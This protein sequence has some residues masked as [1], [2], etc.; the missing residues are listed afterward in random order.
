MLM[1]LSLF[2][3]PWVPRI[4]M[5]KLELVLLG[6]QWWNLAYK[7]FG[8]STTS[9]RLSSLIIKCLGQK[10]NQNYKDTIDK[11]K[12]ASMIK[13]YCSPWIHSRWTQIFILSACMH[14]ACMWYTRACMCTCT[15]QV[16]IIQWTNYAHDASLKANYTYDCILDMLVNT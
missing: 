13:C 5:H 8:I 4:A 2:L 12:R 14:V 10:K 15:C 6:Y 16:W 9:N 7:F 1:K 11:Q 3:W